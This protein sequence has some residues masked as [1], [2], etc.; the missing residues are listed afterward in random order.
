MRQEVL[1]GVERRR[2]WSIEQKL[3]VLSEVGLDGATVADVARRHD[4]SRQHIYQWRRELRRRGDAAVE[5]TCFLPVEL[6]ASE[7]REDQD[8]GRLGSDGGRIEIALRN[9]RIVRA[10][11]GMAGSLLM[12]VIRVAESA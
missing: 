3:Q 8:R 9:G 6:A 2:R 4:I 1:I 10:D 12:R 7:P 11:A 5:Q